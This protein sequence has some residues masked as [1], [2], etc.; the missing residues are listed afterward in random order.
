MADADFAEASV[1]RRGATLPPQDRVDHGRA[2][3]VI[4]RNRRVSNGTVDRPTAL[5]VGKGDRVALHGANP[6]EWS[7]V[8][9]ATLGRIGACPGDGGGAAAVRAAAAAGRIPVVRPPAGP[10]DGLRTAFFS[11]TGSVGTNPDDG[12]VRRHRLHPGP[13]GPVLP[14]M[15]RH[16]TGGSSG[17]GRHA[18]TG[19]RASPHTDG[20]GRQAFREEGQIAGLGGPAGGRRDTGRHTSAHTGRPEGIGAVNGGGGPAIPHRCGAAPGNGKPPLPAARAERPAFE[21]ERPHCGD[22]DLDRRRSPCDE[23]PHLIWVASDGAEEESG[24]GHR[25]PA[26]RR[27]AGRSP[28]LGRDQWTY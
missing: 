18:D 5:G 19:L 1:A 25:V 28:P 6:R 4:R 13:D 10:A 11:R 27:I 23:R 2:R 16:P 24:A 20:C 15:S 21:R 9:P 17:C 22:F 8:N 14:G 26:S 7:V 3:P 12:S